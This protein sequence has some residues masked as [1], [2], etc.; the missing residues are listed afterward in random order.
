[1]RRIGKRRK[2]GRAK[3]GRE[4]LTLGEEEKEGR[5]EEEEDGGGRR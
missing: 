5:Q 1:M 2:E 3:A 4:E